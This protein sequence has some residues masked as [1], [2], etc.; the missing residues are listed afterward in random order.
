MYSLAIPRAL[1]FGLGALLAL[2]VVGL[3][4]PSEADTA[5]E[6]Y[7]ATAV[8]LDA[9]MGNVAT[10]I[11]ILIE[12]WSSDAERDTLFNA[13]FESSPKGLLQA[14]QRFKRIGSIKSPTSLGYDLRYARRVVNPDGSERITIV[15]DRPIG[16][17]ET[18]NMSRTV[19]YPYT[20]IELRVG[21]NG[22]GEGKMLV[23]TRIAA[24]KQDRTILLEDYNVQPVE[25]TKVRREK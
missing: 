6:R 10:P 16:F 14:V 2:A 21:A 5:V 24:D 9:P 4:T 7:S 12:R 8:Q 19:D 15:T 22:E 20:V 17:W 23:G 18:I 1:R 25:L 11:D 3:R 13:I